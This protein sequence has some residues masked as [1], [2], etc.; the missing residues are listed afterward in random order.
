MADEVSDWEA[1]LRSDPRPTH[2]L[3]TLA[4]T[5]PDEERAWDAVVTLHYRAT[6]EVLVTARELCGS[7]C[8]QERTL[9]A[10]ILGQ[11]GVPKRAFP[12]E[13]NTILCRLLR[14]ETDPDV[15]QAACVACGH[16]KHPGAV[17]ALVALKAHPDPEVRFGVVSGLLAREDPRAVA[18]LIELSADADEDIRDWATFGLGAQIE[19]D[20]PAIRQALADRL[21]D[22]H[23]DT[24]LEAI[25]G[26][27]HR[28]DERVMPALLQELDRDE[29]SA[30][31]VEAAA[32]MGDPRLLP[33]LLRLGEW[34]AALDEAIRR[35][36]GEGQGP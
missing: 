28:R 16:L 33:G 22:P 24:R 36:G 12:D 5:E 20:T 15:L 23:E 17:A 25:W 26:L 6:R 29:V 7:A 32:E 2:E 4:L 35:C 8:P 34:D 30:I 21:T 11:L 14:H 13:A 27:A 31:A 1:Q 9:G 10:N 19:Q 3:I 18:A